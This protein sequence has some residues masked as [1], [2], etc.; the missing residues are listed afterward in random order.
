MRAALLTAAP[1]ATA[2]LPE[3][4]DQLGRLVL[5]Q[6]AAAV[7]VIVVALLVIGVAIATLVALR[8]AIGIMRSVEK[9]VERLAPRAEPILDHAARIAEDASHISAGVR[10][11]FDD[12]QET[13]SRASERLRAAAAEAETRIREFSLVLQVVQEEAEEILLETAAAARGLHTT[14]AALRRVR[15]GRAARAA[16]DAAADD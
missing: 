1:Q 2:Q 10:R 15:G 4:S 5:V 8:R 12:V 3:I 13:V 6:T 11:E 14:A 16:R 9:T 7:A